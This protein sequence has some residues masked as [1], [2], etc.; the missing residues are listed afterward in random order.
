MQGAYL[1]Y[2]TS[3]YAE[4]RRLR[5]PMFSESIFRHVETNLKT[6]RLILPL[7]HGGTAIR[8]GL[9]AQIFQYVGAQPGAPLTVPLDAASHEILNRITLPSER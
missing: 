7:T 6:A 5:R 8:I 4:L 1:D 9:M 3:L 2:I